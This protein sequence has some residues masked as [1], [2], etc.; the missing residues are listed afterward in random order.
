MVY[1]VHRAASSTPPR[2]IYST[3]LSRAIESSLK[4]NGHVMTI[5]VAYDNWEEAET[6]LLNLSD[7]LCYGM[8]MLK[9]QNWVYPQFQSLSG[10]L[11]K[12][13]HW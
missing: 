12:D 5:G 2:M 9:H 13:G 1:M 6:D 11:L 3:G 7:L 10:R 8:R 4:D